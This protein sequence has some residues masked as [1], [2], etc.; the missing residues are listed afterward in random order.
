M[1]GQADATT[2]R[3]V[4]VINDK[5]DD[6]WTGQGNDGSDLAWPLAK[7]RHASKVAGYALPRQKANIAFS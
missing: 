7:P 5:D 4:W 1:D 6:G 3:M 2:R